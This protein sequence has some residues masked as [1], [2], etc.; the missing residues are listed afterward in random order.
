[1]STNSPKDK[2]QG[3]DYTR[4][5]FLKLVGVTGVVVTLSSLIPFGKAI[6]GTSNNTNIN[7]T[8]NENP[9]FIGLVGGLRAYSNETLGSVFN[10]DPNFSNLPRQEI[11]V[12]IASGAG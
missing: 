11:N 9:E 5:N 6:G 1:V 3:K 4:R 8:G 2:V 12:L 10:K 7:Q